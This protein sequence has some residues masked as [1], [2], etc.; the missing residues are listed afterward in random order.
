MVKGT[1]G[2]IAVGTLLYTQG[3]T[4]ANMWDDTELIEH[5]DRTVEAYRNQQSKEAPPFQHAKKFLQKQKTIKKTTPAVKKNTTMHYNSNLQSDKKNLPEMKKTVADITSN[6]DGFSNL[7]MS[8]YYAG[9]YTG[10]YMARKND[11]K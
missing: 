9:Y 10:L 6:Q 3:D 5:W 1:K 4:K 2:K 11:T 8:W 7:V